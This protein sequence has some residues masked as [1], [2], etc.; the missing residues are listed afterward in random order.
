MSSPPAQCF[1]G[2]TAATHCRTPWVWHLSSGPKKISGRTEKRAFSG[3]KW[4]ITTL[5]L[6][7]NV[8]VATGVACAVTNGSIA[9]D[10]ACTCGG[11]ECTTAKGLICFLS[12]GGVGSCHTTRLFL[13]PIGTPPTTHHVGRKLVDKFTVVSGSCTTSGLCF[14][15]V[16]YPNNYGNSETCSIQVQSVGTGEEL[17]SVA[18]NTESGYDKLTI[19][20]IIYQGTTGPSNVA[21]NANDVFSWRSDN[22]G[23]RSGFQ[24]CL[25]TVCTETDGS[26]TNGA[27]CRCGTTICSSTTGYYCTSSLSLCALGPPC[28]NTNGSVAN[29]G[30]GKERRNH[31]QT[32]PSLTVHVI[33]HPVRGR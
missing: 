9:N 24:V 27:T 1:V 17:S 2:A 23:V 25:A 28:S 32:L 20:G 5:L 19:G 6:A 21:V 16:N 31:L 29:S 26:T 15:S 8:S 10:G 13:R 33:D 18:F 14:Q 7:A 12:G 4:L 3:L 30:P 11:E 22:G